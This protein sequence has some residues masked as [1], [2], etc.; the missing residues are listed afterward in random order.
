[1]SPK[2]IDNLLV[3]HLIELK[4]KDYKVYVVNKEHLLITQSNVILGSHLDIKYQYD[5]PYKLF[6]SYV[7]EVKRE[8]YLTKDITK[9]TFNTIVSLVN[10][11][12]NLN[13]SLSDWDFH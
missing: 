12:L 3:S 5:R 8:I 7:G 2:D 11:K 1:M 10:Q 4:V 9:T 6:V 13:I